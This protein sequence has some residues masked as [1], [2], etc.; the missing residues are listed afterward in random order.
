M[1]FMG[2]HYKLPFLLNRC[3]AVVDSTFPGMT[4]A[5]IRELA[6]GDQEEKVKQIAEE[7]RRAFPS[8][9]HSGVTLKAA[10]EQSGAK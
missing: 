4:M 9:W 7:M 6:Q 1:I 8:V 5:L 10:G 2:L 3:Q